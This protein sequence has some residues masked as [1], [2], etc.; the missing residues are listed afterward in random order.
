MQMCESSRSGEILAWFSR[1]GWRHE[2]DA[3]RPAHLTIKP[4]M[5]EM[6]DVIVL[7]CVLVEHKLRMASEMHA[8]PVGI[9]MCL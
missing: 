2:G 6:K 5:D 9:M 7:S 4:E 8:E 1:S 3:M